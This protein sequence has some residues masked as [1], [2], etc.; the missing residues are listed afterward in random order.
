MQGR[1]SQEETEVRT[2]FT[3]LA[4]L[5]TISQLSQLMSESETDTDNPLSIDTSQL[6][7]TVSDIGSHVT[8]LHELS[9]VTKDVDGGHQMPLLSTE[10]GVYMDECENGSGHPAA[11]SRSNSDMTDARNNEASDEERFDDIVKNNLIEEQ[12]RTVES[13]ISPLSSQGAMTEGE[14]QQHS[15]PA[16]EEETMVGDVDAT[17]A[18]IND[19][20]AT[21]PSLN[22]NDGDR[23]PV[24]DSDDGTL[25]GGDSAGNDL[26]DEFL[27]LDCVRNHQVPLP[28]FES[29]DDSLSH[30]GLDLDDIIGENSTVE[31]ED[32]QEKD[33]DEEDSEDEDREDEGDNWSM[34]HSA[35]SL[36]KNIS[37][38]D[39]FGKKKVG[40]DYV[41]PVF[42]LIPNSDEFI[43]SPRV[44]DRWV[45]TFHN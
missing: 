5:A 25:D 31:D 16:V 12:W 41:E 24:V 30:T 32:D 39:N 36:F 35:S 38:Y 22:D 37:A 43:L 2:A 27:F 3:Q 13:K 10:S 26:D 21:S 9:V 4:N 17:P 14:D 33:E 28:S 44:G 1:I 19:V 42:M 18:D 15:S 45:H 7:D 11:F 8:E 34:S 20:D 40:R 23:T 29:V 6:D